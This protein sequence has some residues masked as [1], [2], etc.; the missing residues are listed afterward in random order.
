MSNHHPMKLVLALTVAACGSDPTTAPDATP[1]VVSLDASAYPAAHPP[2]PRIVKFGGATLAHPK[3]VVVTFPGD[4]LVTQLDAYAAMIPTSSYWGAVV[5]DY[6]IAA[7]TATS[8]V[9]LAQAAATTLADNSTNT[10]GIKTWLAGQLDGT[11]AE[12]PAPDDD[13]LYALFYPPGSAGNYCLGT[14]CRPIRGYHDSLVLPGGRAVPYAVVA[15]FP[16]VTMQWGVTLQGI[17]WAAGA[18]SH[19][20]V[21]AMTNPNPRTAPAYTGTDVDHVIDALITGGEVGD[22]CELEGE[23]WF[24]PADLPFTVQR[25]WSNTAAASGGD[26][27][28]PRIAGEAYFNSAPVLTD[29]VMVSALGTALT[30]RGIAVA[31]GATKT[32]ELDLFSDAPTPDAW[33]LSASEFPPSTPSRL[34]FTFDSTTG[35]NG[36]KRQLT[37]HAAPGAAP[38][39][40]SFMIVSTLGGR[41]NIW[42]V[43]ASI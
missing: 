8:P 31:A 19:E 16:S 40:A 5:A 12:W 24:E 38:G 26:P 7:P 25:M 14:A 3:I 11:H 30:T 41:N 29:A 33:A 10:S 2:P 13:T 4:P 23:T 6:G 18:M 43:A 21:E 9:H 28:L 39:A 36:D 35:L 15:R 27:C 34:S 17:D 1:D 22:M 20:L 42:F 37:V 32:I